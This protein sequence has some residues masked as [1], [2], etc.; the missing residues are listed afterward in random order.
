MFSSSFIGACFV[1]CF[2]FV[3]LVFC[4]FLGSPLLRKLRSS[5]QVWCLTLYFVFV[6][7]SWQ[8]DPSP[9]GVIV[10]SALSRFR[11]LLRYISLNQA[12]IHKGTLQCSLTT[13]PRITVTLHLFFCLGWRCGSGRLPL[14]A[15][16]WVVLMRSIREYAGNLVTFTLMFLSSAS[17]SFVTYQ[18]DYCK[19][20]MW[21]H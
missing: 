13:R 10:L 8:K 17:C 21:C 11:D 15:R 12:D 19:M 2:F 4:F 7:F 16:N 9:T 5:F 6:F 18:M 14:F 20:A 3:C 1:F